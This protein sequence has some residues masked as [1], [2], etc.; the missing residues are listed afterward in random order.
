MAFPRKKF[1]ILCQKTPHMTLDAEGN[2]AR[3]N[4]S[5]ACQKKTSRPLSE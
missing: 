2:F 3:R 4:L 5:F 1:F